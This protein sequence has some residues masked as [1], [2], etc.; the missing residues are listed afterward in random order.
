MEEVTK[1]W[2]SYT[3]LLDEDYIVFSGDSLGIPLKLISN[4]TF[5]N[6]DQLSVRSTPLW[7]DRFNVQ[8]LRGLV[9]KYPDYQ[10]FIQ[11]NTLALSL[12]DWCLTDEYKAI[13]LSLI[14]I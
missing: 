3:N 12:Q 11:P 9:A 7:K 8:T 5:S 13:E 6:N 14:H 2:G 10:D 1:P 4:S